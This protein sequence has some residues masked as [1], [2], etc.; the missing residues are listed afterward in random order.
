MSEQ[1]NSEIRFDTDKLID[2]W[3]KLKYIWQQQG[4]NKQ[5]VWQQLITV[6]VLKPEIQFT[7]Y[8][9][10]DF[11]D[12]LI[13]AL[14]ESNNLA[15]IEQSKPK[16]LTRIFM[17]MLDSLIG[18]DKGF[19]WLS[20]KEAANISSNVWIHLNISFYGKEYFYFKYLDQYYYFCHDEVDYYTAHIE[21]LI[22]IAEVFDKLL[23][24]FKP[25]NTIYYLFNTMNDGF[26]FFAAHQEKFDLLNQMLHIP[27]AVANRNIF[28]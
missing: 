1:N 17:V 28:K 20:E 5:E 25:D 13:M 12:D 18:Y 16:G 19:C 4:I 11:E 27:C 6:S 21:E 10:E 3:E 24:I 8:I 14:D 15:R 26:L 23:K 2:P 22:S 7:N 9:N